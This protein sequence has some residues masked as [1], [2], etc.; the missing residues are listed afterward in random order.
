MGEG[1]LRR[2]SL[3]VTF[4]HCHATIYRSFW[5][6]TLLQILLADSTLLLVLAL[7]CFVALALLPTQLTFLLEEHL[8]YLLEA[9]CSIIQ[10]FFVLRVII[11]ESYLSTQSGISRLVLLLHTFTMLGSHR[12]FVLWILHKGGGLHAS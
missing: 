12:I 9:C 8:Y 5:T 7:P 11:Q 6:S 2:C 10:M 4:V 1:L 3:Q